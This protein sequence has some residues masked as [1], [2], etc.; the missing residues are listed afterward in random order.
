MPCDT[1]HKSRCGHRAA[2]GREEREDGE[3]KKKVIHKMGITNANA[4]KWNMHTLTL[5]MLCIYFMAL[6]PWEYITNFHYPSDPISIISAFLCERERTRICRSTSRGTL[7]SSVYTTRAR[8]QTHS[9]THMHGG[10]LTQKDMRSKKKK[11]H[12]KTKITLKWCNRLRRWRRRWRH[13]LHLAQTK[14]I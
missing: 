11:Q 5:Q 7:Q 4:K 2:W 6:Y 9:R 8:C 3:R 1:H 10:H 13:A 14:N 12:K